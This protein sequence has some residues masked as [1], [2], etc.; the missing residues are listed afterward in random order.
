[1]KVSSVCKYDFLQMPSGGK[2]VQVFLVSIPLSYAVRVGH[3]H[4]P[5]LD[6]LFSRLVTEVGTMGL[7]DGLNGRCCNWETPMAPS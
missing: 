2:A 7:H 1:M 5:I 3:G 6:G 4:D